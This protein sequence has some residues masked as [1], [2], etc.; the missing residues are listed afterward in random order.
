MLFSIL[1]CKIHRATVTESNIDYEGSITIDKNLMDA[2]GIIQGEKIHVANLTN[3]ARIE[4]YAM[5]GK[6]GSGVICMN[7]GAALHA[8][9]G[10]LVILMIYALMTPEEAKTFQPIILKVDSK[11]RIKK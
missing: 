3:G 7:G 8:K 2:A 9:E 11:N 6:A 5:E 10:N 4:T 1:K